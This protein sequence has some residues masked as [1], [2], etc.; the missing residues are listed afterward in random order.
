MLETIDGRYAARLVMPR[1]SADELQR[2]LFSHARLAQHDAPRVMCSA[3][4]GECGTLFDVQTSLTVVYEMRL[5]HL[6][7]HGPNTALRYP[8]SYPTPVVCARSV[9]IVTKGST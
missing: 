3:F 1:S 8:Y 9:K 5:S 7:I 4:E 2:P 6:T